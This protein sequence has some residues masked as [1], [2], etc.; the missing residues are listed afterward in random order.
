MILVEFFCIEM[1][2]SWYRCYRKRF[3][4]AGF[5]YWLA[6]ILKPGLHKTTTAT[7]LYYASSRKLST[8]RKKGSPLWLY[9][10]WYQLRNEG[11]LTSR[12]RQRQTKDAEER[13]LSWWIASSDCSR[14]RQS[15]DSSCNA[16]E[17]RRTANLV[18]GG[19]W[20]PPLPLPQTEIMTTTTTKSRLI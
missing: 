2:D 19:L 9:I 1:N 10:W 3:F 13:L 18:T 7:D 15:G 11:D 16:E 6:W 12:G 14:S 20:P 4:S 17:D 8:P 5:T